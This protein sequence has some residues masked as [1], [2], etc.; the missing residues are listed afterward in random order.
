MVAIS[1][2]ASNMIESL[3]LAMEGSGFVQLNMEVIMVRKPDDADDDQVDRHNVVQQSRDSKIRTPAIDATSGLRTSTVRFIVLALYEQESPR[4]V[5]DTEALRLWSG[6][7]HRKACIGSLLRALCREGHCAMQKEGGESL[8]LP[9]FV[10]VGYL[11]FEL[12]NSVTF[13][14]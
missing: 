2:S 1:V 4:E 3:M 12:M 14:L 9:V 5:I 8:S 6:Q 7:P 11:L 13:W 10:S